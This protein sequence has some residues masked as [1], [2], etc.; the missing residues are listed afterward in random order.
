MG[1]LDWAGLP[2]VAEMLGVRDIE[3]LIVSL[4]AVRDWHRDNPPEH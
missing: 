1:G 3:A 4:C 2:V